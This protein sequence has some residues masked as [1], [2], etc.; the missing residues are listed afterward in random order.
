MSLSSSDL[1]FC[2]GTVLERSFRDVIDAARA[3]DFRGV[4]IFPP[5]IERSRKAGM[6][7]A[8]LVRYLAD[9]DVEVAEVECVL[10]WLPPEM[11]P[12]EAR[13]LLAEAPEVFLDLA[14]LLGARTVL[15]T[16]GFGAIGERSEVVD[17]FRRFCDLAGARGLQVKWEFLPWSITPDAATAMAFLDEVDRPNTGMMIDSWHVYRGTNDLSQIRA[18]PG[19][20]ILGVQ[21]SDAP[22]EPVLAD[23]PMDSLHHRCLPGEGAVDMLGFIQALDSTGFSGAMGAEVFSDVLNGLPAEEVGR[24]LGE[25]TRAV[26]AKA[27]GG[28]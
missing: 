6:S 9:H 11:V 15:A 14:E 2:A 10:A 21:I 23:L 19:E 28:A 7:D 12:E 5:Q 4:S 27:R 26:I 25:A 8:E 20:Q 16:D 18:L 22:A 13:G 3:G 17:A 24:R 1:V